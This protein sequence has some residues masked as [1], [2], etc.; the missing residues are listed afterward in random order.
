MDLT[1]LSKKETEELEQ[2]TTPIE[3]L[4]KYQIPYIEH[5]F[6][7]Q[8]WYGVNGLT[9][10]MSQKE[11]FIKLTELL[12]YKPL[13]YKRYEYRTAVWGFEWENEKFILYR[14]ERGLSIQVL[15]KFRKDK[16]ENFLIEL[17]ML[18]GTN[19]IKTPWKY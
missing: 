11:F 9:T 18:L 12:G 15:Q 7:I 2:S 8:S 1:L 6:K 16:L 4:T 10:N 17:S 14:S 5:L 19:E 13:Y 3:N